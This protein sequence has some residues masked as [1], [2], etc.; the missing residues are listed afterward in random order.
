MGELRAALNATRNVRTRL[1]NF[2]SNNTLDY[3]PY[4]GD[5]HDIQKYIEIPIA[6]TVSVNLMSNTKQ[7]NFQIHKNKIVEKRKT[8]NKITLQTTVFTI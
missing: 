2:S 7:I 1:I 5:N 8:V 4:Y 6:A 3:E